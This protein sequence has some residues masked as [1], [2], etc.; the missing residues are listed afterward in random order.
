MADD[1]DGL[2]LGVGGGRRGGDGLHRPGASRGIAGVEHV[3]LR[4]DRLQLPLQFAALRGRVGR[5]RIG[6]LR[7]DLARQTA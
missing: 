6:R 5:R 7:S 2:Q 1:L 3:E 4:L